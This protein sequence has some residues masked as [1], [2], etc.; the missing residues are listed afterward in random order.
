MVSGMA[1]STL[2][3]GLGGND[4]R[5]QVKLC[6]ARYSSRHKCWSS[7]RFTDQNLVQLEVS[8]EWS[9]CFA[10]FEDLSPGGS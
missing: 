2:E 8:I 4:L 10:I 7:V 5:G 1:G 9:P 6:W 3:G